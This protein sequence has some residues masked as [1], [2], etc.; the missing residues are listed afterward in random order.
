MVILIQ[1]S[2]NVRE[3]WSRI[4]TPFK[5]RWPVLGIIRHEVPRKSPQGFVFFG[6][7][8]KQEQKN[9]PT[10]LSVR[11][12]RAVSQLLLDLRR[13]PMPRPALVIDLLVLVLYSHC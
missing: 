12:D 6:E 2:S 13:H 1:C 4:I 5:Q 3:R 7:L 10:G 9:P 8:V 11:L